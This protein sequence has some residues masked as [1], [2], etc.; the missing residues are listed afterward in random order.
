MQKIN[1]FRLFGT[2]S[3]ALTK[4]PVGRLTH[5]ELWES[6]VDVE[7]WADG[8][9]NGLGH[10]TGKTAAVLE[11]PSVSRSWDRLEFYYTTILSEGFIVIHNKS[12]WAKPTKS[13]RLRKEFA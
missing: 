6:E 9:S 5:C 8:L 11:G 7:V 10:V 3:E 12:I 2:E 13:T 4:D 1:I